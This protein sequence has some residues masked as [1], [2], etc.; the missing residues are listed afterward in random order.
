M[1]TK[2]PQLTAY[3]KILRHINNG[4]VDPAKMTLAM[5][6][7]Y[8]VK[9]EGKKLKCVVGCLFND[10]QRRDLK[11]RGL[12]GTRIGMVTEIIGER[13]ITTVTGLPIVE[14]V[15]LQ[16]LHDDSG[17]VALRRHIERKIQELSAR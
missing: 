6:Y 4:T 2:D 15:Q 12:N 7:G 3:K 16:E 1:T 5:N 10:A 14:L 9:F 8:E 17:D 11:K 13:N